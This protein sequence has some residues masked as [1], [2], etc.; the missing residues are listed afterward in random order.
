MFK[1]IAPALIGLASFVLLVTVFAGPFAPPTAYFSWDAYRLHKRYVCTKVV[2]WDGEI[3]CS[4]V[5]DI[6]YQH[7]WSK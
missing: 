1:M 6:K 2:G 4:A 5:K 3:P 7:A